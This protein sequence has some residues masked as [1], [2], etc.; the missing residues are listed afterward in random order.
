M[1]TVNRSL[2]F[3][4]WQHTSIMCISVCITTEGWMSTAFKSWFITVFDS[5]RG[6][7]AT[8]CFQKHAMCATSSGCLKRKGVEY[9]PKCF[10]DFFFPEAEWIIFNRYTLSIFWPTI[11]ILAMTRVCVCPDALENHEM[12][13]IPFRSVAWEINEYTKSKYTIERNIKPVH[14]RLL[15]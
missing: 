1:S 10:I 2:F 15:F 7:I 9:E 14:Y 6:N 12:L 13:H 3:Q 8:V 11:S 4:I 5:Q